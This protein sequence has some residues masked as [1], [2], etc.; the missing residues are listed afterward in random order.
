MPAEGRRLP[1][2]KNHGLETFFLPKS[3]IRTLHFFALRVI[4]PFLL[5]IEGSVM[6]GRSPHSVSSHRLYESLTLLF[7]RR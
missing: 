1:Q 3:F 6:Q 4:A 5:V 2:I 7:S